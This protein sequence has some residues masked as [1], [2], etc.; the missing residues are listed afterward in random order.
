MEKSAMLEALISYYSSGNKA[1]FARRLDVRPQT[2]NT[3]ISRGTFDAELIYSKCDDVSGDWLLS[4][5]GEMLRAARIA[6][7]RTESERKLVEL[8]KMLVGVF[9]QKDSIMERLIDTVKQIDNE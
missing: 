5:D 8:C 2:I 3:W 4:G 7:N 1:Q 6:D 9:E